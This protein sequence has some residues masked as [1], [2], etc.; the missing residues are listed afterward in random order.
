M[1]TVEGV[2]SFSN[3]RY[4]WYFKDFFVLFKYYNDTFCDNQIFQESLNTIWCAMAGMT[5]FVWFHQISQEHD[6]WFFYLG[7]ILLEHVRFVYF[8]KE[9][10]RI[11]WGYRIKVVN[12]MSFIVNMGYMGYMVY[13]DR[14]E[15]QQK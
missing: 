15:Q 5:I 11:M 12:R 10:L 1:N 14:C 6:V 2:A 3:E 9:V 8:P 13:F 4:W 7:H